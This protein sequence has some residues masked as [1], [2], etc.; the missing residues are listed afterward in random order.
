MHKTP[1]VADWTFPTK[2]RL[3]PGRITE[4]ANACRELGIQHPLLVT[5]P[6]LANLP[7]VREAIMANEAKGLRTGLFSQLQS[8]PLGS[9][10][11]SGVEAFHAGRHDSIIAFGGGSAMDVGKLIAFLAG[12]SRP[13]WDF[14]D[15]ED[16]WRRANSST[17]APIIAIPTTS[18]TGSEVGRAGVVTD[19]TTNKKRIIYHPKMMPGIVICDPELVIGLPRDLT[20]WT[21]MDALTHCLEAYCAI[22]YHPSADGIALEGLTLVRQWLP[23]A[24]ADGSDLEARTHM[25]AAAMMG[26]TAFQKGLGAIHALSH[27]VSS[28]YDS[29]HGLT[30][31]V[32]TPYVLMFNKPAITNRL[33]N[34]ARYLNLPSASFDAVIEWILEL[35]DQFNIFHTAS[36]LGVKPGHLDKLSEMASIDPTGAS[37]PITIDKFAARSMYE[38]AMVGR[39]DPI[40]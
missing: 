21:G 24:V 7:M 40:K 5:D 6:G 27:P 28:L 15:L 22:G 30:N 26:A 16:Y 37:N 2:I 25:M 8:N 29:H 11:L 19:E 36:E 9:N 14:E 10:V 33:C 20:A 17:I 32:F 23:R 34:L 4:L 1:L 35:R 3:G 39:C 38:A 13:L 31:A 18:G 12:Q